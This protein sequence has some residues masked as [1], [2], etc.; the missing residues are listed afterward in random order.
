[1]TDLELFIQ[2]HRGRPTSATDWSA[3]KEKWLR[4]L[5]KLLSG[6]QEKLVSAGVASEDIYSTE[7][8][9]NEEY[10]GRYDAPG[11]AW[12]SISEAMR[13]FFNQKAVGLWARSG[14]WMF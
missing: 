8:S 1:M 3:R 14:V 13:L 10:L 6:I 5:G 2:S 7:H 4:E 12:R 9:L 11:L